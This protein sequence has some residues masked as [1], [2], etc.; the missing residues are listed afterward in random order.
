L[1]TGNPS[2]TAEACAPHSRRLRIALVVHEYNRHH[3]H[4]RYVAELATRFKHQ[5]DVHVFA[6]TFEEPEPEGLTYHHVPSWRANVVTTLLTFFA[7]ATW[8]L[9]GVFDIVHAQGVCGRRQNV[10]TAHICNVA[11]FAAVDRYEVPQSW[12][13]KLFRWIVTAAERMTYRPQAAERFIAVSERVR[14]DLTRYHGLDDQ[15]RVVYHGTDAERFRP[16]HQAAWRVPLRAELKLA[17]HVVAALYVGYWQ[18]AGRAIVGALALVPNVKLIVVSRTP[19]SSIR[20]EARAAGVEDRLHFLPPTD[21]IHRYYAAADLFL[22]PT[23]YDTFGLVLT[24][25]MASGLPVITNREAGA[26]ELIVDGE[27]GLLTNDAWNIDEIAAALQKLA[28]D[29]VLRSRIGAA[30]RLVVE[31]Y[32]WD[33]TAAETMR[34]YEEVVG[35]TNKPKRVNADG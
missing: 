32:T 6:T 24:E 22:F 7:S 30:G 34:V 4:S 19:E 27:S 3:G 29:A 16:S 9:R 31:K 25:A 15:V 26:A 14:R 28:A 20:A 21:E 5:H 12:R 18:K 1:S 10:V 17:E 11:W 35:V 33:R 13:K 2:S 8:R 23:F